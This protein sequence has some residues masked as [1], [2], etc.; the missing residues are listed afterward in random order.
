MEY[1]VKGPILPVIPI[2]YCFMSS[3]FAEEK[4]FSINI[5]TKGS[6]DPS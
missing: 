5:L 6:E 1:A 3:L 2:L 4:L